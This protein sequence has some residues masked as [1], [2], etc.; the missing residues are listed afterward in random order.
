MIGFIN[1]SISFTRSH[2]CNS[3][4]LVSTR[5]VVQPVMEASIGCALNIYLDTYLIP[6]HDNVKNDN[7]KNHSLNL[8][9]T[10]HDVHAH[11][12]HITYVLLS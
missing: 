5:L 9:L 10:V 8:H 2:A 3:L 4:I 12:K 11:I 1:P 6:F 7:V